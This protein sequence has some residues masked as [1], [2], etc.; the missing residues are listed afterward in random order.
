MISII[1]CSAS[2]EKSWSTQRNIEQTIEV[3]HEF[4]IINN[5]EKKWP[6]AKVYNYGA[7]QAKYPFLL[8]IHEDTRFLCNGW[9][10]LIIEKLSEETTGVI[11][12]AGS[13]LRINTVHPGGWV[14]LPGY[15]SFNYVQ[16]DGHAIFN[17][18][19]K[20]GF[21]LFREG[22]SQH[23]NFSQVVTIDG[24]AMFVR[25]ELWERNSF[26]E[27]FLTGFHCYDID[28]TLTLHHKGYKNYICTNQDVVFLHDSKG[29]YT[30]DWYRT[31][32]Y[33]HENKWSKMLP[34]YTDEVDISSFDIKKI[35]QK[36]LY[37]FIKKAVKQS[38]LDFKEIESLIKKSRELYG[39]NI[40]D[41]VRLY[42][43]YLWY[44]I[45]RKAFIIK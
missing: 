29:T 23:T 33:I 31:T 41:E 28:F 15:N 16:G 12:F 26:D 40:K 11:G 30:D 27:V 13:K 10:E 25:K 18:T 21:S 8:F 5:K 3:E 38:N 2:E 19:R 39:V 44:R 4:I 7:S 20:C 24:M 45:L 17:N 36:E 32:L 43:K 14:S 34:A 9:A 42:T 22:A 35:S 37:G 6:I 1:I